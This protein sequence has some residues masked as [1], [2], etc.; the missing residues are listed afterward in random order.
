MEAVCQSALRDPGVQS[1]GPAHLMGCNQAGSVSVHK[2]D[3]AARLPRLSD[4][5]WACPRV[6]EAWFLSPP[7]RSTVYVTGLDNGHVERRRPPP[8]PTGVHRDAARRPLYGI[9]QLLLVAGANLDQRGWERLQRSLDTD[10]RHAEVGATPLAKELC[11]LS[12]A[13][14]TLTPPTAALATRT[15]WNRSSSNWATRQAPIPV[16]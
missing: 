1:Q 16:A 15:T 8:H 13:T 5:R 6:D 3:N 11:E 14:S 2:G 7:E 12:S 9:R 10:D 4:A